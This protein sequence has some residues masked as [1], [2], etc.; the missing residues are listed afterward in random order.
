MANNAVVLSA[1]IK[2]RQTTPNGN[3][4]LQHLVNSRSITS[5]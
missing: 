3:S 5:K 1:A 4:V 2:T